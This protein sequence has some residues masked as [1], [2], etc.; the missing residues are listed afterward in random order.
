MEEDETRN[1]N[2]RRPRRDQ[3]SPDRT[4][5]RSRGRELCCPCGGLDRP[6]P[7]P[8]T[9]KPYTKPGHTCLLSSSGGKF[10]VDGI[11]LSVALDQTK[12]HEC[13]LLRVDTQFGGAVI[14]PVKI[15]EYEIILVLELQEQKK[16]KCRE[17]WRSVE[18]DACF[19]PCCAEPKFLSAWCLFC[20]D[21]MMEAIP[22][23]KTNEKINVTIFKKLF[24]SGL[25]EISE[26]CD[27]KHHKYKLCCKPKK[28]SGG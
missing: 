21:P 25:L 17:M 5:S 1:N 28:V 6:S 8:A 2:A 26:T 4:R 14:P 11:G 9:P 10:S 22:G 18:C 23:L 24:M 20:G 27:T 16:D 15:T 12:K 19:L 13:L 3:P 7:A